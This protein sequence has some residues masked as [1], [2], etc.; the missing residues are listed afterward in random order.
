M[1][2]AY[3]RKIRIDVA[4]TIRIIV[5]TNSHQQ[6]DTEIDDFLSKIKSRI[7]REIN[8]SNLKINRN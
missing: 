7:N 4:M 6:P 5:D 3:N 8:V 2:M 1:A